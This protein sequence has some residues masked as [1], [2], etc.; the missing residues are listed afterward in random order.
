MNVSKYVDPPVV[1]IENPR[2][3]TIVDANV[4][5]VMTGRV[6]DESYE[7]ELH[8][9][10]VL[11]AV[12]GGQVC[13]TAVFDVTGLSSCEHTF[14]AG[15]ATVD[16]TATDPAGQTAFATIE[17]VVEAGNAPEVE[18]LTPSTG[19]R[20]NDGDIVLFSATVADIE[21]APSALTVSW[22]SD[23]DGVLN[24]DSAA[25]SG[26]VEFAT[27]TLSVGT[28][29]ISLN[30]TDSDGN[31]GV[32]RLTL[33]VNGP[34]GAP[35]VQ[36]TP[37]PAGADDTLRATIV[38]DAPDP[39]GDAITYTYAWYRNGAPT[40]HA[41]DTVP[42]ADTARGDVWEVEATPS[43]GFDTGPLGSDDI[44]IGNAA[45][46]VSSVTISPST[47]YTNDTLT[48]VPSGYSDSDGDPE[49]YRYQWALNGSDI[50]GATDVTLAGTY[51][52]KGDDLTVTV[53]P[54]DGS[55]AGSAVTSG[56]REIQNSTPTA[57]T[58]A[59]TP[60]YPEDDD[61][62]QCSIVANSTDAD[63]DA[64]TYSYA[65]T[66]NGTPSATTTANVSASDTSNADIW[67]CNITPNDGTADGTAGTDTVEV[68]DYTAPD[69]PVLTAIDTFRNED[70]VTIV[71]TSEAFA[72]VTL[73]WTTSSG[74]GTDT[75]TANAAGGFSFSETLTRAL[76]YSFYA[77]ATDSEGNTS[78]VS[79]TVGTEACDPW[80]EYEDSAGYGDTC[81]NP[82]IDWSALSDAGTTTLS[83]VGNIIAT[84]DDDWYLVE[85]SDTAT[86]GINYY[87]FHVELVDGSGDYAFVVYDGGCTESYLDCGSGSS[88][89]PE[90]SGYT[91]Y[92]Y[93]AQDVGDGG[94]SIP[95]EPRACDAA[96]ASYNECDDLSSD[97]YIHVI[98]LSA[99]SCANYELEI[100]NG[101]W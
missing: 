61:A 81:T 48:A 16:I 83:V 70:T 88:S 58:V 15:T 11:W 80:D 30:I 79:N 37:D 92:Q 99:Y 64:I 78:G 74:S 63:G 53:I 59:I 29:S 21:D 40:T 101:V 38:T 90:G 73:Y 76:T 54:W 20:V 35:V 44:V 12:N 55:S 39:N 91:E 17:L 100:T 67:V 60:E 41:G 69:A 6:I 19:D 24:D 82:V 3:G 23:L 86:S 75:T 28:H 32:D 47:A 42:A 22:E 10:N 25:S 97:Y 85:T 7:D 4:P 66:N 98:R 65:W 71:G 26:D 57:P 45:P 72:T 27:D 84:G 18:I 96:S 5:V 93:Y 87:N 95:T 2:D 89:D 52:S 33:F 50:A 56:V 9:I 43:D 31:T 51:F 49:A 94:H 36:I 13:D 34:P 68:N 14:E 46:T 1:A 77:T 62:L 8:L